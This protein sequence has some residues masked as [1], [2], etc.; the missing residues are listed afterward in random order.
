[1][2]FLATATCISLSISAGIIHAKSRSL[3]LDN[4]TISSPAFRHRDLQVLHS[5]QKV[6]QNSIYVIGKTCLPYLK[7][8]AKIGNIEKKGISESFKTAQMS[9]KRRDTQTSG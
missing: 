6:K 5:Y 7:C 3:F 4:E 1:M 8:R 9:M 2:G